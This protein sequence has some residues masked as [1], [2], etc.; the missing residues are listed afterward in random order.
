MQECANAFQQA[1]DN[2][3]SSQVLAHYDP[4]LP[5]RLAADTSAYGIGAVISHIY[6]DGS[7]RPMVFASRTLTSAE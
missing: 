5:I 7:E 6:P 1:K 3:V 4:K 2:L